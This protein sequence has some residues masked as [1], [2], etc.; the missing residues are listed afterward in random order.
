M[1]DAFILMMGDNCSRQFLI[2]NDYL[3]KSDTD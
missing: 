1:N 3:R 2:L